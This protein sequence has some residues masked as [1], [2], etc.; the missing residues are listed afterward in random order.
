MLGNSYGPRFKS[1][2]AHYT[3]FASIDRRDN[4][5][6]FLIEVTR[7]YIIDYTEAPSFGLFWQNRIRYDL[8]LAEQGS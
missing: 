3:N 1:G 5:T 2:S 7:D 8:V 4:I 6:S